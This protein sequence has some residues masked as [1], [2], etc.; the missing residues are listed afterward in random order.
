VARGGPDHSQPAP[1]FN[2]QWDGYNAEFHHFAIARHRKGINLVFF[3]G[4][5]RYRQ[6]RDLWALPWHRE[7]D[8]NFYH[9]MTFPGWMR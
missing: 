2:G 8:V 3:D 4:S 9:K 7:F 1:Q 6:A 5:V